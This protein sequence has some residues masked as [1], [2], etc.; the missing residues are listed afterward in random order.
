MVAGRGGEF[1]IFNDNH[2]H[3][4]TMF[5]SILILSLAVL[6]G[7]AES[8]AQ[9]PEPLVNYNGRA[10]QFVRPVADRFTAQTGIPVVLHAGSSTELLNKLRV[11]GPRTEADLYLSNDAGTLQIGEEQGLFAEL[12]LLLTDVVPANY[13]GAENSWVG[14]AARARVLVVN[15]EVGRPSP[16]GYAAETRVSRECGPGIG[17]SVWIWLVM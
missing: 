5:R 10:E 15:T 4:Q 7:C 13:R 14:L 8:P 11:E 12:P 6:V 17:P 2:Y 3:Y 9:A 16:S 1:E